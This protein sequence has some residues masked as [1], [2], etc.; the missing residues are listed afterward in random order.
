VVL[1]TYAFAQKHVTNIIQVVKYESR[2]HG[3]VLREVSWKGL[4]KE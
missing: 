1:F 4:E 3:R 2:R